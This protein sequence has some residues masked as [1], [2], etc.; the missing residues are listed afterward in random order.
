[1]CIRDRHAAW[2]VGGILVAIPIALSVSLLNTT[3]PL[4]LVLI[5]GAVLFSYS[6]VLKTKLIWQ[7]LVWAATSWIGLLL[8]GLQP[9]VERLS[10]QPWTRLFWQSHFWMGMA[11]IALLLAT[12]AMQ[13][14][15]G[16]NMRIRR[17]H[18]GVNVIISL[19]LFMQAVS[20]TRNLLL[21]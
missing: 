10:D 14:S 20:G 9:T 11:L 5:A 8:L 4:T 18:I 21:R 6:K 16:R 13:P 3:S 1:M 15:I 17:L 2:A 19:L 7:R 12:T